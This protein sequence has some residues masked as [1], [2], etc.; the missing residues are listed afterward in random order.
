MSADFVHLVAS[1]GWWSR[2]GTEV[3]GL[4]TVL[5]VCIPGYYARST[6]KLIRSGRDQAE[7]ARDQVSAAR[8]QIAVMEADVQASR[9]G[10]REARQHSDRAYEEAVRTRLSAGT[11]TVTIEPQFAGLTSTDGHGIGSIPMSEF[12]SGV[13]TVHINFRVHNHGPGPS[14]VLVVWASGQQGE[15]AN[16]QKASVLVPAGL[17]I[18]VPW[19]LTTPGSSWKRTSS[20]A[21]LG[22]GGF[23]FESRSPLTRV[24]DRHD[25][26]QPFIVVAPGDVEHVEG[27]S[28]HMSPADVA[29][30]VREFP[31]GAAA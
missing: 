18:T 16:A 12:T 15:F 17:D 14:L 4:A 22:V 21:S 13:W 11:P 2:N 8:E 31:E 23:A 28:P 10:A 1:V 7:A 3:Q 25:W 6:A 5:L 24:V 19:S 9:D 30:Q 29:A 26:S 27:N 20:G